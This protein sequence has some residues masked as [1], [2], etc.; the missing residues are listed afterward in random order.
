MAQL[1]QWM[2]RAEQC[3]KQLAGQIDAGANL[4]EMLDYTERVFLDAD[5]DYRAK[6]FSTELTQVDSP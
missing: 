6:N 3:S 5:N 1:T 2:S 4:A